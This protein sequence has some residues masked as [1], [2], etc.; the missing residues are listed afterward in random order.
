VFQVLNVLKVC[1][2]RFV[3]GSVRSLNKPSEKTAE[4]SRKM[5]M[6]VTVIHDTFL[7]FVITAMPRHDGDILYLQCCPSICM[8]KLECL[9]IHSDVTAANQLLSSAAVLTARR[10]TKPVKVKAYSVCA[11]CVIPALPINLAKITAC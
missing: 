2:T 11:C 10:A 3:R 8:S 9:L 5:L 1:F 6:L 4:D 7:F